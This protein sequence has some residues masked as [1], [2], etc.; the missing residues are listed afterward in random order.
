MKKLI[1]LATL[2]FAFTINANAQDKKMTLSS[3]EAATKDV[4]ALNEKIKLND[5]QQADFYTLMV[6]KHD[7][8]KTNA[9]MSATDKAG[10]GKKIQRKIEAAFDVA[11]RKELAKYPELM[12]RL[13]Q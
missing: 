1:A 11:Q 9:T 13:T 5:A 10:M 6:M 7:E 4:A 8:L 3:Q 2:F 12:Q